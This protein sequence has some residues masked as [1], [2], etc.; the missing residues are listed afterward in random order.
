MISCSWTLN[1]LLLLPESISN[2]F[3]SIIT[4]IISLRTEKSLLVFF[5]NRPTNGLC[6]IIMMMRMVVEEE[7]RIKVK[8]CKRKEKSNWWCCISIMTWPLMLGN[9]QF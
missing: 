7:E 5:C 4:I 6:Y 8:I 3:F 2:I 9:K 1:I